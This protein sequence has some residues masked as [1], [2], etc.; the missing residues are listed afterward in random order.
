MSS[1]DDFQVVPE[2]QDESQ[3]DV[4]ENLKE[5]V[6]LFHS[7]VDA[8]NQS[9]ILL[10]DELQNALSLALQRVDPGESSKTEELLKSFS[11]ALTS[12]DEVRKNYVRRLCTKLVSL[13]S[14]KRELEAECVRLKGGAY[15]EC[16][17]I[18]FDDQMGAVA[19]TVAEI[20]SIVAQLEDK[21]MS[22]ALVTGPSDGIGQPNLQTIHTSLIDIRDRLSNLNLSSGQRCETK[23]DDNRMFGSIADV[24]SGRDW[25]LFNQRGEMVQV[26][27]C[28]A[29]RR[30]HEG[31]NTARLPKPRQQQSRCRSRVRIT[32]LRVTE[33]R[34]SRNFDVT[35]L[36]FSGNSV[37]YRFRFDDNGPSE[38]VKREPDEAEKPVKAQTK[39]TGLEYRSSVH[40]RSYCGSNRA[41]IFVLGCLYRL[42][43]SLS[44][45]VFPTTYSLQIFMSADK[46]QTDPLHELFQRKLALALEECYPDLPSA[47]KPNSGRDPSEDSKN[48]RKVKFKETQDNT[49]DEEAD[50]KQDSASREGRNDSV[51][52]E[53]DQQP[54]RQLLSAKQTDQPNEVKRDEV[55][56]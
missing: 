28:Y 24:F 54:F 39:R 50:D 30:K 56:V 14:E 38:V 20:S 19:N 47:E 17:K 45:S 48:K 43:N 9:T 18:P 52:S 34:M 10:K 26:P 21:S 51:V 37:R 27:S 46:R 23:A 7:S 15:L 36:Q 5:L 41:N 11:T 2:E 33:T 31:Q 12:T 32:N 53:L 40:P 42:R 29:T 49:G 4:M 16:E 55:G 1:G 13:E 22:E 3:A 44:I 35:D 8:L 6:C 25:T